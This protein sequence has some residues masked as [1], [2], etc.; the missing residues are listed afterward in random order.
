MTRPI[1]IE[2]AVAVMLSNSA[3]CCVNLVKRIKSEGEYRN[4]N[5]IKVVMD[6]RSNALY[7][8]RE[9]IPTQRLLG[10]EKIPVFKPVC[11]IPFRRDF[12]LQY[13]RLSPTP[14]EW[15]KSIAS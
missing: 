13:A 3:I 6:S 4:P 11:I 14:L 1:M 2:S 10:F 12:L 15:A 9:P 5:T 8:S 7:F